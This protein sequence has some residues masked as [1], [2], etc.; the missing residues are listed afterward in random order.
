VS[1][2]LKALREAKGEAP[3]DD[4]GDTVLDIL[5]RETGQRQRVDPYEGVP[6]SGDITA[7]APFSRELY[8]QQMNDEMSPAE[9]FAVGF[10]R[11]VTRIGQAMTGQKEDP[12]TNAAFNDLR[13]RYGSAVA[14]DIVGTTTTL[15]PLAATPGGA[16]IRGVQ[17]LKPAQS[18]L[19][20][21]GI[22][23]GAG[24]A[25]GAI[26]GQAESQTPSGTAA[27]AGATA[28]VAGASDLLFPVLG[29]MA[30]KVYR[31][32]M[33]KAPAGALMTP[34]GRPTQEL[35]EALQD[36]GMSWDDLTDEAVDFVYTQNPN[37]SAEELARAARFKSQGITPT[38]GNITQDF[39]QQAQEAR[40]AE[41]VDRRQGDALR[42][43]QSQ[44][45]DQFVGAVERQASEFGNPQV[46][47]ES[48]QAALVGREKALRESRN[49]LY[50][51]A[52]EQAQDLGGVPLFGDVIASALPDE[53]TMRRLSRLEGSQVKALRDLLVEFGIDQQDEA[54][55]AFTAS[56]GSITPLSLENVEDFRAALNLIKRSD[57][58]GAASVAVG[59][60]MDSL[61]GELN[62]VTSALEEAGDDRAMG[63]LDTLR[64]A[65]RQARNVNTEFSPQSIA[66]R[67]TD[68]KRDGVTPVI[69]AS[70]V[71]NEM[72]NKPVEQL[73]RTLSSLYRAGDP[74]REAIGNLKAAVVMEALEEA[75]KAP[76]NKYGGRQMANTGQFAKFLEQKFGRDRLEVLFI[77]DEVGLRRLMA[78]AQSAKDIMPAA[79]AIP[80]GSASV[81]AEMFRRL[82][83]I[84]GPL[85]ATVMAP[86]RA[87]GGPAMDEITSRSALSARIPQ[88]ELTALQA[89]YP[90]LLA[91]LGIA[92]MKGD[93]E[94]DDAQTQ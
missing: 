94:E 17:L 50:K 73:Q 51:Q 21:L 55:E 10:D 83:R 61:D 72:K 33:N 31:S 3:E 16:T 63:L 46:A 92:A 82:E 29:R 40:L 9:R 93:K 1:E 28:L 2:V 66:G 47:G 80:K 77:R 4:G 68:T 76:S 15:G 70:R 69:E 32:V 14:G 45:S 48:I 81:N 86:I 58:S 53:A 52:A 89:A 39:A 84:L 8:L 71:L 27:T 59:P 88:K 87:L 91:T 24:A 43:T 62:A 6:P 79:G 22:S 7:N 36:A 26:I 67:L 41:A 42:M 30:G 56:G 49:A 19:G 20:R 34:D 38:T 85:A 54:V 57:K 65:R 64:K 60:V 5:R 37:A 75:L 35:I 44:Q 23:M 78:L 12:A 74:G 90:T 13:D 18:L 11:G 25:E